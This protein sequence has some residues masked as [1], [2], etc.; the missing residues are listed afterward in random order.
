MKKTCHNCIHYHGCLS[1]SE[2]SQYHILDYCDKFNTVLSS[3]VEAEVNS[4][5]DEYWNTV[6]KAVADC[7]GIYNDFET[8][9]AVCWNFKE[10][11][12]RD[13]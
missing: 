10:A 2:P 1:E 11:S 5:L 3:S 7:D 9:D 13:V 6:C 12:N 8:G 4:F